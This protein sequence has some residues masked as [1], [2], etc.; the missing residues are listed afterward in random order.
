[1]EMTIGLNKEDTEAVLESLFPK[2][3]IKK[4]LLV[5]P[6]DVHADMF[7]LGPAKRRRYSSF[8]PYG[9]G[10]I[11]THLREVDIDVEI[12][13]LHHKILEEAFRTDED[14]DFEFDS[15]WQ[16]ALD[17][18]VT[19]WQPDVIGVTCMFTM[20]HTSFK[21][22]CIRAS[23]FDVPVIAGG[24]HVTNDAERVMDDI[25]QINIA[26]LQE[27]DTA[28]KDF[29][30]AVNKVGSYEGLSQAIV[31]VNGRKFDFTNTNQPNSEEISVIPAFDLLDSTDLS[32]YGTI[33]AFIHLVDDSTRIATVLSNRGCRAQ[34]TFCSVS[35]FNGRGVRQR[36]VSSVIDELKL[37]KEDYGIGHF[38][39]LDDDLLKDHDRVQLLFEEMVRNDLNMTWDA[40]NGVIAASCTEDVISAAAK[41]G[42]IGLHIGME[43][44]NPQILRQ[45][46]KPG[47]VQSFLDAAKVLRK[48]E[49]IFS[50][51]FLM[52]G[53]PNE[54]M[55]MI[56]DT[57]NVAKEM[58]LDWYSIGQLQPLPNTP[59]FDD[60]VDQGLIID[61]GSKESRFTIG[62][63]GK[64]DETEHNG[65]E[66]L[67]SISGEFIPNKTELAD[68]WFYMDYYLNYHR[69]FFEER[70]L[71]IGQQVMQLKK[72]SEILYPDHVFALYFL[73]YFQHRKSGIIDPTIVERLKRQLDTSEYW[74]LR[75]DAFGL[76]LK[77]LET[78]DFENAKKRFELVLG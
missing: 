73:G 9:L 6:P 37:L 35:T 5:N 30:L 60:M 14:V 23:G 53:F 48:H 40:T 59:I 44:G 43:S 20:T 72:V 31:N 32:R 11:A 69:L 68:V 58:D 78:G 1:M 15:I 51:V 56:R 65:L 26:F 52:I 47:N 22:V 49:S 25:P 63:H 17:S 12:L 27:A 2:R 21:N 4:I 64:A 10:V 16:T 19:E 62:A 45:I 7:K 18:K 77:D 54:T 3:Q 76:S 29:V 39:W 8:P 38:M 70:E 66:L 24:V 34:C 28:I 67:D 13:N 57:I 61:V 42:C 36:S 74:H 71:K 55:S 33:G 46:K 41:S 50:S 75:F